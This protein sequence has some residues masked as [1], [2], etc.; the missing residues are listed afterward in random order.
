MS[1]DVEA[2]VKRANL[3]TRDE[4]LVQLFGEDTSSRLL[5][6]IRARTEGQVTETRPDQVFIPD[7][8]TKKTAPTTPRRNRL[9]IALAA[10]LVVVIA[11]LGWTFFTD[12][13]VATTPTGIA[14]SYLDAF[15]SRD[16]VAVLVL[17]PAN[18]E[19]AGELA[20]LEAI[21]WQENQLE[22]VETAVGPP[23]TVHCT[24]TFE[25]AWTN[26]LSVGPYDRYDDF[27]IQDG[28]IVEISRQSPEDIGFS[29]EAWDVF[30]NWMRDKHSSDV[31]VLYVDS[32][33]QPSFTPEAV[34]LWEQY[35][36]E[37]VADQTG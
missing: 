31:S 17:Y 5:Q 21:G 33:C 18:E 6:N 23:A 34:I 12:S 15:D 2:R 11:G 9:G 25:N 28:L 13:D 22:C 24:H 32:C 29:D 30:L 10:F 3:V 16:A 26:A 8:K 37:F 1:V 14:E 35:T 20:W 36:Q 27:T 19:V 7:D 4:Q